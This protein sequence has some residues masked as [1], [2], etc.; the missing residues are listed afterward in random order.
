[1]APVVALMTDFGTRD[2]YVAAMKAVIASRCDATIL[3]LTHD[4]P[5]F[6]V[7][8]AA[9]VLSGIADY[10]ERKQFIVVAVVDPGVGTDRR[11][12]AMERKGQ[13][14]L[15]P[16]NGLLSLLEGGEIRSVEN[17]SLFL[18]GGSNTFHGRDRFAPVAAALAAGASF[19][20]LGP[21]V[22][23][24]RIVRLD[25]EKPRTNGDVTIGTVISIDRYGNAVTD[26]PAEVPVEGAELRVGKHRITAFARAYQQ[27]E[28]GAFMIIGSRRTF[29]ISV[30]NSSAADLLQIARFDRVELHRRKS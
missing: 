29:E 24:G 4:I 15:A 9:I 12:L 16:D 23:T 18:P 30:A 14:F 26:I 20:E 21:L 28:R 27:A 6:D 8:E 1:M 19:D 17:P 5:P 13:I 2:P 3:D 10:L 22:P 11:L 25:Y 7:F